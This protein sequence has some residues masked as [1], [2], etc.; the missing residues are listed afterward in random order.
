LLATTGS[1]NPRTGNDLW[2]FPL[3][4]DRKPFPYLQ[5]EFNERRPRLSPDGRW[6]AYQSNESKRDE[7]Y[8]VSFPKPG[9]KWQVSTNGGGQPQWS[10]DGRELFYYSADGKIMA[11]EIKPG[12]QFQAGVPKPLFEVHISTNNI[13]FAVAKDGRFLL[14]V[15]LEQTA[16]APMT[17]VLNWPELLKTK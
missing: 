11:V 5:T 3:F 13:G 1:S 12:A 14:P 2:V 10:Q 17:V 16:A 7:V 9:G 4:G 8:V 6:L 15:L